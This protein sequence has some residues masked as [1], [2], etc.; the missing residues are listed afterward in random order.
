MKRLYSNAAA[1]FVPPYG[2]Y[3]ALNIFFNI[4]A[5]CSRFFS[6]AR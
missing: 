6:F 3:L 1:L 2:K 5:V 4:L